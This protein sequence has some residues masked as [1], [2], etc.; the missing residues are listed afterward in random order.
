MFFLKIK[1]TVKIIFTLMLLSTAHLTSA[2][3]ILGSGKI[4]RMFTVEDLVE[5]FKNIELTTTTYWSDTPQVFKGPYLEDLL[6]ALGIEDDEAFEIY[7]LDGYSVRFNSW[8]DVAHHKPIVAIHADGQP[9][10][11]KFG[12]FFLVAD[13]SDAEPMEDN[14]WVWAIRGIKLSKSD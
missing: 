10:N 12:P 8:N 4:E 5:N 7:A 6:D 14:L 3:E 11:E 9:L 1:T 2:G 13:L